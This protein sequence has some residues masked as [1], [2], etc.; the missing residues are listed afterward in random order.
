M[1]LPRPRRPRLTAPSPEPALRPGQIPSSVA[2]R[3]LRKLIGPIYAPSYIYA[4]GTGALA[5][6]IVLAALALGFSQSHASAVAGVSG[7]VAVVS[8]PIVGSAIARRS[9]KNSMITASLIACVTLVGM[10]VALW[11]AG[12]VWGKVVYVAGLAVLAVAQNVYSLAR[13]SY[14]AQS[15]PPVFRPRALSTYG[16][17]IRLGNLTGPALGSAVVGLW[18]LGAVFVLHI[19]TALIAMLLIILFTLPQPRTLVPTPGSSKIREDGAPASGTPSLA[20]KPLLIRTKLATPAAHPGWT[21]PAWR[22]PTPPQPPEPPPRAHHLP[23]RPR[24]L[25]GCRRRAPALMCLRRWWSVWALLACLWCE[26]TATCSSPCGARLWVWM[27]RRFPWCGRLPPS[28]TC[29][30]FIRLAW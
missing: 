13:Q 21:Q 22:K 5:P 8:S 23:P 26:P 12:Q 29:L 27:R 10:F 15:V 1:K 20:A 14:V 25:I 4:V 28:L 18:T 17:M 11:N 16:G 24:A 3:V 30:C 19:A 6:M 2:R 7:L 9:E